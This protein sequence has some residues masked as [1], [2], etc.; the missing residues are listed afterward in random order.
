ML[1]M[2][3][4]TRLTLLGA[5]ALFTPWLHQARAGVHAWTGGKGPGAENAGFVTV[6]PG[7]PSTIWAGHAAYGILRAS[8]DGGATWTSKASGLPVEPIVGLVRSASDANMVTLATR[9]KI[10]RSTN[11]GASWTYAYTMGGGINCF[12]GD[13]SDWPWLYIGGVSAWAT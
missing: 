11:G 7:A 8:T 5:V 4:L 10:Y 2:H 3:T 9:T 1:P 13:P 12:G 6:T